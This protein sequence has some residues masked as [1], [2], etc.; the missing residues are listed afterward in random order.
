M[1]EKTDKARASLREMLAAAGVK[2][3]GK[4]KTAGWLGVAAVAL[5]AA[6]YMVD[7]GW[8]A[9]GFVTTA[10]ADTTYESKE[11]AAETYSTREDAK[12]E[13]RA[14]DIAHIRMQGSIDAIEREHEEHERKIDRVQ[15][16][17]ELLLWDRKIQPP[18]EEP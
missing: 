17:V 10:Y 16:S 15:R 8:I 4:K 6:G 5:T 13:R 1:G 3:N 7:K 11:H 14:S 12:D 9:P 18:P 2:L